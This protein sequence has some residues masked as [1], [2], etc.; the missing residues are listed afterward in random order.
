MPRICL[1]LSAM[2]KT[3]SITGEKARYLSTVLRCKNGDDLVIF[4]GRGRSFRTL[5]RQVTAK[6]VIAEVVDI[7]RSDTESP[8][9]MILIQGILKGEKM[10]LVVQKTTELG[11]NEII[12]VITERSVLKETR[13][14]DRWKKVAED[15]SRQCGRTAMP[16]VR[17]LVSFG[18]A[19]RQIPHI[20]SDKTGGF[21][22]YE[23]GGNRLKTAL[24]NMNACT[25]AIT[26]IGPEGGFTKE[27][28]D[29]A[30]SHG[31]AVA[32]LGKRILR[33]ETAAIAATGVIQFMLGDLS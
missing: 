10:D 1:P 31:F 16:V 24:E 15:A 28:V 11:I 25:T 12:P 8:L 18:E 6:A 4:D 14:I 21:I 5:I 3:V 27:E 13:K 33:A 20:D 22:L 23:E 32:S 30:I 26:A 7:I 2:D 19:L 29:T 9:N 17:E